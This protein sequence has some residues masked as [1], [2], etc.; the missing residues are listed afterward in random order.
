MPHALNDWELL[1]LLAV[2]APEKT[3]AKMPLFLWLPYIVWSAMLDR[4][5]G[6]GRDSAS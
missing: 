3:G 1:P 4:R 2:S 5:T 6:E